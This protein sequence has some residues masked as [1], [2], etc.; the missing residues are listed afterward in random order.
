[1][2]KQTLR[3]ISVFLILCVLA[4]AFVAC[5]SGDEKNTSQESESV[6]GNA[7]VTES[8]TV[9]E[10]AQPVIE[11]KEYDATFHISIMEAS[12]HFKYH[13]VEESS[14]DA[15]S[16][17]LFARQ[18]MIYEH[19]GVD[20]V[21]TPYNDHTSYTEPFKTSVKNKDDTYQ[22]MLSHV[23]SGIVSMIQGNYLRDQ[24]TVDQFNLDADYW[25]REFMEG[26]ALHD[27]MYLGRNDFNILYTYVISYNKTMMEQYG[28]ALES[29][30]YTLVNDYKWTLDKMMNLASLVYIDATAD[31]KTADDTFGITGVQWVPYIGFL[32]A[33][34]LQ[35]I[36]VNEAGSYEV[37][38]YNELNQ[39]KTA[40]LIDKLSEL[41]AAD[42]SWFRFKVE[43][44]PVIML[45]SG[46][47]L[48]QITNTYDLPSFCD[49]DVEFGILPFPMFDEAQA[50]VGY[51]HLQ[52]GGY[53]CM[54]SYTANLEM[55]ADTIE[56]LAYFSDNVNLTFYEKLLGK[57][58]AD[59]PLDKQMLDLVWDTIVPEFA[60]AYDDASGGWLYMV[61]ELTAVNST[62]NLASYV[63]GKMSSSNKSITKFLT[64]IEKMNA[65]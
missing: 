10:E 42:Y 25:N 58:V 64:L 43:P 28:S 51:R 29:D 7:T 34:N 31:G 27:H 4:S 2:K 61:P 1:M 35:Y 5:D 36:D 22:L 6:G 47:A 9:T 37:V 24:A 49:Y 52:W 39:A 48:M 13:W 55:C 62:Y 11:K 44:T 46:R 40:A 8:E 33:S 38:V 17:A 14:G 32:H 41:A 60:Q 3:L 63:Q 23:H 18:Q 26:L 56:M 54:P 19:L 30:V 12:N 50:K 57:Q 45:Y 65:K 59:A 15:M 20:I 21:A 53:L 16:E